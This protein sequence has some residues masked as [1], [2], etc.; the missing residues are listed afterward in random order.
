VKRLVTSILRVVQRSD[1]TAVERSVAYGSIAAAMLFVVWLGHLD[2]A[3]RPGAPPRTD[4]GGHLVAL[5]YLVENSLPAGR[6]LDWSHQ[7]FAGYPSFYFYFPLPALLIAALSVVLPLAIA[8]KLVAVI[9]PALLPPATY[10]LVRA[11]GFGRLHGAAAV[12]ASV[13]FLTLTAQYIFGGNVLSSV[14]GEYSFAIGFALML[15]YLSRVVRVMRGESHVFYLTITLAFIALSHLIPVIFAAAGSCLALR[16]RRARQQVIT[17]WVAGFGLAAFWAVPFLVRSPYMGKVLW[18]R[19]WSLYQLF[20]LDTLLVAP[21]ALASVFVLRSQLRRLAVPLFLAALAVVLYSLPHGLFAPGRSLPFWHYLLYLWTGLGIATGLQ[22]AWQK[23]QRWAI[24]AWTFGLV[25]LAGVCLIQMELVRDRSAALLS[26]AASDRQQ[27]QTLYA[28]L[29][30]LPPA[31][32]HWEFQGTDPDRELLGARLPLARL[33]AEIPGLRTT[34]GLLSE[35]ALTSNVYM[36]LLANIAI[37]SMG[38]RYWRLWTTNDRTPERM[39]ARI[40]A[41]GVD[42]LVTFSDT[43]TA[44]ARHDPRRFRA[45]ARDSAWTLWQVQGA[46]LVEAVTRPP[47]ILPAGSWDEELTQWLLNVTDTTSWPVRASG[48]GERALAL[49]SVARTAQPV[50]ARLGP[51]TVS[52]TTSEIG[53]PHIVRVGYFPN[54][55]AHGADGPYLTIPG[56]MMVIPRQSDVVLRFERTWVEFV[57]PAISLLTVLA[58]S[59]AWV[60]Q[61]RRRRAGHIE[62]AGL[63]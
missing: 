45:V 13:A 5:Q 17:S 32:V 27:Y 20:P 16:E 36:Y 38:N 4:L 31:R 60:I 26:T 19:Y 3:L 41:L 39:R 30:Q 12:L 53:V 25:M 58:L 61:R 47:R 9:A 51:R 11:L 56:F 59:V 10:V 28:Q 2:S 44:L 33:P 23:R 52:F 1:R 15:F 35:S 62:R 34:Q 8:A 57:A 21:W 46:A 48:N 18:V 24:P 55:R 49:S 37:D 40:R 63:S 50:S 29:A 14:I 43:I 54:W 22:A 6:L 42:Y 7:W